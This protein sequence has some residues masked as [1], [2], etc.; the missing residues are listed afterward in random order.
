MGVRRVW[1]AC[2][3]RSAPLDGTTGG[4]G[5]SGV[6]TD[7]G[8]GVSCA[9][10]LLV[11]ACGRDPLADWDWR[12][13]CEEATRE[14]QDWSGGDCGAEEPNRTGGTELTGG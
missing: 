7:A 4:L 6:A 3:P 9:L 8:F 5:G 12:G 13:G 14:E 2:C 1:G 11:V 10:L